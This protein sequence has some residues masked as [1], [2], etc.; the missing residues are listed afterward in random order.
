M[1]TLRVEGEFFTVLSGGAGAEKFDDNCLKNSPVS[2]AG[3]VRAGVRCADLHITESLPH[4]PLCFPWTLTPLWGS[5]GFPGAADPSSAVSC[6][7]LVY[8]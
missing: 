7:G 4:F 8:R 2:G 5:S 6:T 1:S 3:K